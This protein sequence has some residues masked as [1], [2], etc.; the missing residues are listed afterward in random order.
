MQVSHHA[1]DGSRLFKSISRAITSGSLVSPPPAGSSAALPPSLLAGGVAP[2]GALLPS[3]S[4]PDEPLPHA[5]KTS[6]AVIARAVS[7]ALGDRIVLFCISLPSCL[8]GI[9]INTADVVY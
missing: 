3:S 9:P 5:D 6:A 2:P 4:A 1:C 7:I 8:C